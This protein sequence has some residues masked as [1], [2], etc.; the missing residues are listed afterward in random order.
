VDFPSIEKIYN[1]LHSTEMSCGCRKPKAGL[2][3][4]ALKEFHISNP[5][6]MWMVGDRW[7]DVAAGKAMGCNTVLIEREI[8]WRRSGILEAPKDLVAD[9]TVKNF[10]EVQQIVSRHR[11]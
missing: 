7:V 3:E 5:D 11:N 1:C 10:F 6:N 4:Q 2:L 8:S 9:F